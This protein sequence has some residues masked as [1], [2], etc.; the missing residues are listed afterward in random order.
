MRKNSGLTQYL[1]VQKLFLI[2]ILRRLFQDIVTYICSLKMEQLS[3]PPPCLS[4]SASQSSH[5]GVKSE[6]M[7]KEVVTSPVSSFA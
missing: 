5:E 3:L 6:D 1:S 2:Q 4:T 7:E